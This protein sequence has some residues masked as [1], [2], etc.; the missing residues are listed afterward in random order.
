MTVAQTFPR[1]AGRLACILALS[2]ATI[3]C[4]ITP[5]LFAADEDSVVAE[6]DQNAGNISPIPTPLCQPLIAIRSTSGSSSQATGSRR[7]ID[8]PIGA[9]RWTRI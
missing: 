1:F 6:S 8:G 7:R 5:S 2:C 9:S 4:A 3:L